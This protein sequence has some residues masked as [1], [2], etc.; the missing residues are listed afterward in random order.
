MREGRDYAAFEF[1][2]V[3][4][5]VG[6]EYHIVPQA[7]AHI[8]FRSPRSTRRC[9]LFAPEILKPRRC[10][11]RVSHRVLN[12]A[13]PKVRWQRPRVVSLVGQRKPTGMPQHVWVRLEGE[14]GFY[15]RP[16]RRYERTRRC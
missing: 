1:E 8:R 13:V 2:Q 15:P 7:D 14:L 12:V 3:F 10:Q 5:C 4:Q 6:R 9:H 16:A 11:L